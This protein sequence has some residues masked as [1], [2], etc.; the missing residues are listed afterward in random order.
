MTL[1]GDAMRKLIDNLVARFKGIKQH[2]DAEEFRN[3][4]DRTAGVLLRGEATPWG[5]VE[6][7]DLFASTP[8]FKGV[9]AAAKDYNDIT[10]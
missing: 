7:C 8:H 2:L 4:Y 10:R 3:G 5:V 9:L 1:R 6:G